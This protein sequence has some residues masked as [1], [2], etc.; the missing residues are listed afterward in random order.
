MG[1]AEFPEL[2]VRYRRDHRPPQVREQLGTSVG[3]TL[4]RQSRR[5]RTEL[6]DLARMPDREGFVRACGQVQQ[7]KARCRAGTGVDGL[8]PIGPES[9]RW[10]YACACAGGQAYHRPCR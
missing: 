4:A 8:A 2:V 7:G 5:Q 9:A 3:H 10:G 6:W 1:V